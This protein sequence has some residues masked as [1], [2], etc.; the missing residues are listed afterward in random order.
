MLQLPD[1][2]ACV[3]ELG[4]ACF[5][6]AQMHLE[7]RRAKADVA[8]KQLIDLFGKQVSIHGTS[9]KSYVA[10]CQRVS[11]Q[12]RRCARASLS[13]CRARW[14]YVLTVPRGRSRVAAI[15]SRG[16]SSCERTSTEVASASADVAAC[17][18]PSMLIVSSWRFRR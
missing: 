9:T 13:S 10:V 11:C 15:S 4:A 7:R 5:A 2:R 17:G 14:M 12:D 6:C 18:E 16:D 1:Q 8:V 3:V